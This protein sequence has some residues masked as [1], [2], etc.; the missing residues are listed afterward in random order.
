MIKMICEICIIIYNEWGCASLPA[1]LKSFEISP[2]THEKYPVCTTQLA[3]S[4]PS[5]HAPC[6]YS[7]PTPTLTHMQRGAA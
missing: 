2:Q 1:G 4:S 6:Q 5:T 3:P 7:P